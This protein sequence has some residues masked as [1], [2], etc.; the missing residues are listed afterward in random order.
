MNVSTSPAQPTQ[1]KW[2]V[3]LYSA[4]DNNLKSYMLDDVNE[5]EGVGSDSYTNLVAQVDT[6]KACNRYL[7]QKDGDRSKINSPVVESLGKANMSDPQTLADFISWGVKNYPAEHYM[8]VVS[9]HGNGWRGAVEDDSHG[10]WMS[11]PMLREGFEKAQ[12]ATGRKLDIIGFDACLMASAEVTHELKDVADYMIVSQETEGADGW[13]YSHILNPELLQTVQQMHFSKI[14]VE[15]RDLAIQTV[16]HASNDQ[17]VLPTM[18]AVDTAKVPA[19]TAALDNLGKVIA[20]GS[21]GKALGKIAG[22][23]QSFT[24]YKDAF[25]F[26]QRIQDSRIQ[27]IDLKAAAQGVTEAISDAVI[28][29]EHSDSYPRAHGI[30]VEL[31][32]WG[33]PSGYTDT[34][35]GQETAW[36]QALGKLATEPQQKPA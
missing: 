36:P 33:T 9:D 18:T 8:V 16:H 22:E 14:N 13:P 19:M 5:I 28:A 29:E 25:D 10:G 34:K 24:D 32:T 3:L 4:A 6:G 15:P 2:T 12:E 11:L 7:L 1:A 17:G 30:T 20:G 31:S 26:A 23:T 21:H 35:F 27:D